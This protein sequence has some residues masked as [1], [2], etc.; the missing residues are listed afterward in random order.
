MFCRVGVTARCAGGGTSET[1]AVH[2]DLAEFQVSLS[3]NGKIFR[4]KEWCPEMSCYHSGQ[5]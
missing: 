3:V 5:C 1:D 2:S 4:T